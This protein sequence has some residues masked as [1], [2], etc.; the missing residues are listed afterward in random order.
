MQALLTRIGMTRDAVV[1]LAKARGRERLVSEALR[2]AAATNLWRKTSADPSFA[3]HAD[4]ALATLSVIEAANPEDEAL[5]SRL[6]LPQ[7]VQDAGK[8]AALVT[9]DRALGRRVLAALQPLEHRGRGFRRRRARRHAGRIFA[10]LAASA[11][12][13]GLEP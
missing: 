9:A 11:A 5:Q 8:T 12:L 13:G 7:A 4:A 3:A 6:A 2:P 10:R 1:P